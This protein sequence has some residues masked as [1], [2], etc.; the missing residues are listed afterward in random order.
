MKNKYIIDTT[1]EESFDATSKARKDIEKSLNEIGYMA[2]NI[3]IKKPS[4]YF[5]LFTNI[6]VG[7]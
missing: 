4:G 5:Q 3:V 6:I 7:Y 1:F 2:K